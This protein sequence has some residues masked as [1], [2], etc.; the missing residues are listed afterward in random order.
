[1]A[2][3]A[4][5]HRRVSRALSELCRRFNSSLV[6]IYGSQK[7]TSALLRVLCALCGENLQACAHTTA[8]HRGHRGAQRKPE[9]LDSIAAG[10]L[11]DS[12]IGMG[13]CGWLF[14][15]WQQEPPSLKRR[16]TAGARPADRNCRSPLPRRGFPCEC[17]TMLRVQN[18]IPGSRFRRSA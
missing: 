1:V 3:P 18:P 17:A 16:A 8:H 11:R 6:T 4:R 10:A 12:S 2:G 13:R 7:N 15:D 9:K 5:N 14:L